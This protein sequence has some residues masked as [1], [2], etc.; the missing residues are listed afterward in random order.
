MIKLILRKFHFDTFIFFSTSVI[1]L[2][3]IVWCIQAV[4]YFDFVSQ[5]GHGLKVYFKFTLFSFPKILHGILPFVFFIS[6]F[7][8]INNYENNNELFIY[9]INGI[10]RIYFTKSVISFTF[11]IMI[12]QIFLGSYVVPNSQFAA[13]NFLKNSD[14]DL[15]TSLIKEGRFINI[16]KDLTIFIKKQNK[17]ESFTDIFIDDQ[18][19]INPRMIYAKNGVL[20]NDKNNKVFQLFDGKI[21]NNKKNDLNFLEFDEINLDLSN[22]VSNT[23]VVPKLQE[24]STKTL[25]S[26]YIKIKNPKYYDAFNCDKTLDKEIRQVI[27]ER[28]YKPVYLLIL[29]LTCCF[30]L[31]TSK[32]S[33]NFKNNNRKVFILTF[34]ILIFSETSLRYL[35]SS[36]LSLIIYL[37]IP[38]IFFI[39]VYIIFKLKANRV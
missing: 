20:I 9:W 26:C 7:Y 29:S 21:I 25:L 39:I 33:K 31:L 12:L 27:L 11:I 36:K 34:S 4:N 8:T 19:N 6:L 14:L 30:L 17:D 15:F 3:L 10:S 2:G 38:L 28:I 35:T 32:F 16:V 13:R 23:I 5:D 1:V 37:L 18:S 22:Y 24:I